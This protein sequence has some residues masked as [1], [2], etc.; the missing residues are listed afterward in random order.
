MCKESTTRALEDGVLARARIANFQSPDPLV[1]P[2]DRLGVEEARHAVTCEPAVELAH[3]VLV[4][5]AVTEE[6][7]IRRIGHGAMLSHDAHEIS[8]HEV[9]FDVSTNALFE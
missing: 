3:E 6:D 5:T 9:R 4:L 1:A 8:P 2:A 7:A